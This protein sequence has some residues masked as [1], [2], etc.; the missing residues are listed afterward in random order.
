LNDDNIPGP[1]NGKWGRSTI[2][3]ILRNPAYKGTLAWN[4]HT[5]AKFHC[6]Q[7]NGD[8]V[9][10]SNPTAKFTFRP[11]TDWLT[12]DNQWE[13]LVSTSDWEKA[14]ARLDDRSTPPALLG[15][16][17]ASVFL[18]S[19]ILKCTCG[20]HYT[21]CSFKD[22]RRKDH[23]Y[24]YYRCGGS[25]DKGK[26][27]CAAR[28]VKR[29]AVDDY[30]ERRVWSIYLAPSMQKTVWKALEKE[31]K[32]ALS[33]VDIDKN[34]KVQRQRLQEVNAQLER[35]ISAV[36]S[37]ALESSEIQDRAQQLRKE[38]EELTAALNNCVDRLGRPRNTGELHKTILARLKGQLL[39]EIN[40]WEDNS[41]RSRKKVI[42]A[43]VCKV[44]VDQPNNTLTT[45]FNALDYLPEFGVAITASANCDPKADGKKHAFG[46]K[47]TTCSILMLRPSAKYLPPPAYSP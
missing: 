12:I 10:I 40:L 13:G 32:D 30:L 44:T 6:A 39:N 24:E 21:G 23:R 27:V 35:L 20:S 28:R 34:V 19:G 15:K 17:A 36:A 22:K 43:H 14:N 11:R 4:R 26:A 41:P 18:S 33:N 45:E 3:R 29:K 25:L 38:K 9:R 47:S 16:G 46:V 8:I 31:L 5:W 2:M 37:G 1:R 7:A 42:R